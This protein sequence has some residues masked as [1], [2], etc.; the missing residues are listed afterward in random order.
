[1]PRSDPL[2][3]FWQVWSTGEVQT[4]DCHFL[5]P[6]IC[7]DDQVRQTVGDSYERRIAQGWILCFG[8]HFRFSV[9]LSVGSIPAVNNTYWEYKVTW[10]KHR[11]IAQGWVSVLLVFWSHF[12]FCVVRGFNSIPT[13][14]FTIIN[15]KV[16]N[17]KG[18]FVAQNPIISSPWGQ[19]L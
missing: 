6:N 14:S 2:K 15:Q 4:S 17:V 13:V 19:L 1:M 8:S 18:I 5:V 7:F 9:L 3:Y 12:R 10:P 16:Q 11:R